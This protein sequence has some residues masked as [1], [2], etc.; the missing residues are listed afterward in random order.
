MSETTRRS[1]RDEGTAYGRPPQHS[2]K[3][4]TEIGPGTPCG[5]LMRRYWQPVGIA[6]EVT[7]RPKTVRILGEDLV[8]LRDRTG[9]AGLLY[10]RCMHRG[11]TL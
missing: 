7:A 6:A 1:A 3:L 4:L 11:T 5:E 2:N 8:L 9:R 10:P